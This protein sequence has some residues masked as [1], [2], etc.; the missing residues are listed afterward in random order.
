M[1][2]SYYYQCTVTKQCPLYAVLLN[3]RSICRKLLLLSND[4]QKNDYICQRLCGKDSFLRR[5][6]CFPLE[7]KE[8]ASHECTN[9][10]RIFT[11]YVLCSNYHL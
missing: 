3:L 7:N 6:K 8:V 9:K 5:T 1:Q 10:K 11:A 4:F 2:S